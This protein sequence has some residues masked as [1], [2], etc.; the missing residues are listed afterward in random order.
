MIA[1]T[2]PSKPRGRPR[3]H[4]PQDGAQ[5]NSA[6]PPKASPIVSRGDSD[7]DALQRAKALAAGLSASA[8][9]PQPDAVQRAPQPQPPDVPERPDLREEMRAESPREEADRIAAEWFGHLDTLGPYKD[10][11]Y[12]D[13]KNIPDGWS[14][15][16]KTFTVVGKE[17]PQHMRE[18]QRNHWRPVDARRHPEL[19]PTGFA[20][21]T[22]IVDGMVLMERPAAITDFQ[23]KRDQQAANQPIQQIKDKLSGAPAGH[24]PR[25]VQGVNVPL[26]VNTEYLPPGAPVQRKA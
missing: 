15:E 11:Y 24:F 2:A 26:S 1:V 25:Q 23:K 6:T 21:D 18:L 7:A 16:W 20:G 10:K 4:P 8:A 9:A 12:V 19:V 3:K 13:P 5:A 22:I 17:N 14:Y